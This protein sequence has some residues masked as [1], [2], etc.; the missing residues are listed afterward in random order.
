M[1]CADWA[2]NQRQI[3]EQTLDNNPR[4]QLLPYLATKSPLGTP[5]LRRGHKP[6]GYVSPASLPPKILSSQFP[7]GRFRWAILDDLLREGYCINLVFIVL[8][9]EMQLFVVGVG[10]F[11]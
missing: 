3:M 11:S 10:Y 1:G 5:D 8:L 7:F 2:P 9:M 4:L 6:T